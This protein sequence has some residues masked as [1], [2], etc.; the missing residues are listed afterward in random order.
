[1]CYSI[2]SSVITKSSQISFSPESEIAQLVRDAHRFSQAFAESCEQHPLLVYASALPFTPT[3]TSLCRKLRRQDDVPWLAG[4]PQEWSPLLLVITGHSAS[5]RAVI[6]SPDGGRVASCS[7]D[8]SVRIWD[9]TT[10]AMVVPPLLGHDGAASLVNFSPNG[11]RIAAICH[12]T[13]RVWDA[14]TG[15]IV[16]PPLLCGADPV[17]TL[18]LSPDGMRIAGGLEFGYEVSLPSTIKVWDVATGAHVVT[19]PLPL[20]NNNHIVKIKFSPDGKRIAS[21]SF[22]A[23]RIW[24]VTPCA[25]II[26]EL[27]PLGGQNHFT[28]FAF[29]PDNTYIA[30]ASDYSHVVARFT[31]SIIHLWDIATSAYVVPPILCAEGVVQSVEFLSDGKLFARFTNI[32]PRAWDTKSG[33]RVPTKENHSELDRSK[34]NIN[35]PMFNVNEMEFTTALSH[36]GTRRASGSKSGVIRIWDMTQ[37]WAPP[38]RSPPHIRGVSLLMSPNCMRIIT[39]SGPSMRSW[40]AMSGAELSSLGTRALGVRFAAFSRTGHRMVSVS[41]NCTVRAWDTFSGALLFESRSFLGV[42][43]AAFTHDG[44]RLVCGMDDGGIRLI[45]SKSGELI[46]DPREKHAGPILSVTCSPDG[47]T[48]AS[49]SMDNSVRI[50]RPD[51]GSDP[52]ALNGHQSWICSIAFSPDGKQIISA[53][54]DGTIRLWGVKS[55]LM[56]G[57]DISVPVDGVS[58]PNICVAFS[59]NGDLIICRVANHVIYVF[60]KES[61]MCCFSANLGGYP[62]THDSQSPVIVTADGWIIDVISQVRISKLPPTILNSSLVSAASCRTAIALVT[63]DKLFVMH[64]VPCSPAQDPKS[65]RMGSAPPSFVF[66]PDALQ[67]PLVGGELQIE[68]N[69]P[70]RNCVKHVWRKVCK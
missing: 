63:W 46:L 5:V 29:S 41:E 59:P 55:G 70:T 44:C 23:I 16:G 61:G 10:G 62:I 2:C 1:M 60:D 4:G 40:S 7:G 21:R 51:S 34:F 18:A 35:N 12:N 50:W 3:N 11:T 56:S 66:D 39:S 36:D 33:L 6:F 49:G 32:P 15:A 25:N 37:P 27:T 69:L 13:I 68:D 43:T 20:G 28:D 42:K 30:V 14:T 8:M 26:A 38:S 67:Q 65:L 64:F 48:I 24:D 17:S 19:L 31:D 47:S 54:E 22:G 52:M 45:D 9:A 57:T 58:Y 53:S